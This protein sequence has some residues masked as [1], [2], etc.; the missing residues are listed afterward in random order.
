M[1]AVQSIQ[2]VAMAFNYFVLSR[3]RK[4]SLDNFLNEENLERTKGKAVLC[5]GWLGL[6]VHRFFALSHSTNI[7]KPANSLLKVLATGQSF[8]LN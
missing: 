1:M 5:I 3:A 6:L 8:L 2:N 4:S 7:K